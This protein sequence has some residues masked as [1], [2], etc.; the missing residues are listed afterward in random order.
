MER[1]DIDSEMEDYVVLPRG[2]GNCLSRCSLISSL[3]FTMTDDRFRVI[4]RGHQWTSH[5]H[6]T[7]DQQ[8]DG[9][10]KTDG[11]LKDT[12]RTKIRN[13]QR[14]YLDHLDP[15]VFLPLV[16][17]TSGWICEDFILFLF[18]HVHRESSGLSNE[19]P[20][21]SDQFRFLRDVS[22]FSPFN[23]SRMVVYHQDLNRERIYRINPGDP[24]DLLP[25]THQRKPHRLVRYTGVL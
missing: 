19:L 25:G 5:G 17:N 12:V 18:L 24:I 1:G 8:S 16:V 22:Y 11:V 23:D 6:K 7:I 10:P 20:E 14:I 9:T 21:E 4:T 3:D 2:Q 15:I 13:Y